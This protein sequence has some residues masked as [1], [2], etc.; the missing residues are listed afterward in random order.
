MKTH[1][2][3]IAWMLALPTVHFT[4]VAF[5]LETQWSTAASGTFT[6]AANWTNGV[7]DGD[8]RAVFIQPGAS[9]TVTFPGTPPITGGTHY[10][11]DQL[12]VGSNI[13]DF[14]RTFSATYTLAKPFLVDNERGVLIQGAG[15]NAAVLNLGLP[16]NTESATLAESTG[17]QGTL[18]VSGV[19]FN[20]NGDHN[21]F[22][23]LVVS[24][25][26]VGTLNVTNNG[27]VNLMTM[28]GNMAIGKHSGSTGVVSIDGPGS[29]L[30]V[31]TLYLGGSP[32]S[33][34]SGTGTLTVQNGGALNTSGNPNFTGISIGYLSNGVGTITIDGP[35]STWTQG[36]RTSV[37]V[38]GTGVLNIQNG[39]T[40]ND[41]GQNGVF[42]GSAVGSTG[43]VNV[44]GTGSQLNAAI[45][46]GD[47]GT[48]TLN[49]LDGGMVSG[50]SVSIGLR[51]TA[52]GTLLVSGV[53]STLSSGQFFVSLNDG[54]AV[55]TIA[56]GGRLE[57]TGVNLMNAIG[58]NGTLTV[59]GLG[60]QWTNV[61]RLDVNGRLNIAAGGAVSNKD[62]LLTRQVS[63]DGAGSTWS[64]NGDLTIDG[65]GAAYLQLSSGG[66]VAISGGFLNVDRGTLAGDGVVSG[67]VVNHSNVLAGAGPA[68]APTSVGDLVING[69]YFQ[70]SDGVLT[71]PLLGGGGGSESGRL[72]VSGV[73]ELAGRLLLFD[74]NAQLPFQPAA[75]DSFDILD[76]GSLSGTFSSVAL[77]DL[78]TGF[79][80]N[81]SQLYTNGTIRVSLVGD[82]DANNGLDCVDVDSLVA[83]IVSG[84]DD[85]FF[86]LN[87]DLLVNSSDLT[88]WLAL[89][90]AAN[91]PSGNAYR[92]GDANLDGVV[93]GSDF[94]VWNNHKFT[95]AAAWCSGDFTA[96]GVVDGSDFV[97]WNGNKFTS[98]D[99]A[100]SVVPEPGSWVIPVLSLL[101]IVP[102]NSTRRLSLAVRRS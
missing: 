72:D 58:S 36:T 48:G 61:G 92:L 25:N 65:P 93:D 17:T 87:G 55:A 46:V 31:P 18:N 96:D 83:Q 67:T 53:G 73:V 44:F 94:I 95:S 4:T 14:T 62:A 85:P 97:A 34:G 15:G 56:D 57:Q 49:I 47:R 88:V 32:T 50:G 51:T 35:G 5:A 70:R 90:G 40:F 1:R 89:A 22:D 19:N 9:Y 59:T 86:D 2:R 21:S 80:W 23:E 24:G 42:A 33:F 60:S 69:N 76:W 10:T 77:P 16:L 98:S 28:D 30:T 66:R 3:L 84:L 45:G 37:G 6:T 7:P 41:S 64:T 43:I 100:N 79:G 74:S 52:N 81:T 102:R 11:N 82:F 68:V 27:H 91:L 101:G 12:S 13:V 75:G 99:L 39:G 54:T 71:I 26:G 38:E 78:P 8:D 29:S 63:V 20:V